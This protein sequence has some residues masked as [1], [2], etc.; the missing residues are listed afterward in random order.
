MQVAAGDTD[1]ILQVVREVDRTTIDGCTLNWRCRGNLVNLERPST[2][3][4]Q[5][6][7]LKIHVIVKFAEMTYRLQLAGISKLISAAR[8]G[9]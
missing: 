8:T 3:S 4:K 1:F 7:D 9:S 5:E 6:S 2:K